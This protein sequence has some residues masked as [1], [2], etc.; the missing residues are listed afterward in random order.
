MTSSLSRGKWANPA[1][2][3]S[4]KRRVVTRSMPHRRW[5][6]A[7]LFC[8]RR[9]SGRRRLSYS[10]RASITDGASVSSSPKTTPSTSA[11]FA[12][13]PRFGAMAW[14]ASPSKTRRPENNPPADGI[15]QQAQGALGRSLRSIQWVAAAGQ[16]HALTLSCSIPWARV[17]RDGAKTA[18]QGP[19]NSPMCQ[20]MSVAGDHIFQWTVR[21]TH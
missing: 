1:S 20:A 11:V 14:A 8:T 13:A 15:D 4:P 5:R 17:L 12:P 16:P 2:R 21:G 10:T 7:A 3:A 18:I 19:P 9:T 6:I